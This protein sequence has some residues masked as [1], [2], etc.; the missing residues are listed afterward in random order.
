[1]KTYQLTRE[2]Q[3]NGEL[4]P[5]GASVKASYNEGTGRTTVVAQGIGRKSFVV[6]PVRF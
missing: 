2:V 5:A 1:M 6:A 4:I 3:I